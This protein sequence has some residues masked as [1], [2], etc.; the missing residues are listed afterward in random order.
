M[1]RNKGIRNGGNNND[2]MFKILKTWAILFNQ[3]EKQG[4][5]SD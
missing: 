5:T 1:C 2:C 3:Q 4:F